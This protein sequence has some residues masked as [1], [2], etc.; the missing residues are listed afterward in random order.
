M[1]TE[2]E[3]LHIVLLFVVCKRWRIL[4]QESWRIV[5]KLDLLPSTW[6]F[7]AIGRIHTV[8]LRKVLLKCGRYLTEINLSDSPNCLSQSTLTIIG[9]LCPN[10]TRIDVSALTT[11][12][13]GLHVLANNCTNITKFCLGPSIHS[14]D[15]D[16]KYFFLMHQTLEYFAINNNTF[17]GKCLSHLPPQTIHT[18]ILNKCPYV[19]DDHVST[20]SGNLSSSLFLLIVN[21]YEKSPIFHATARER[22]E[23][24]GCHLNILRLLWDILYIC[25]QH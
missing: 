1:T 12:A 7:S 4:S 22:V 17:S 3:I 24:I 10:L 25:I 8:T 18:I 13:S 11:C 23:R 2:T 6:G 14:L 5:K 16:L 9:K 19:Q 20:V 15:N 21:M